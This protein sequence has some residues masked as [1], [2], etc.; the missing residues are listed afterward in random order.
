MLLLPPS[1]FACRCD[2]YCCGVDR[3]GKNG[4]CVG[5]MEGLAEWRQV[6]RETPTKRPSHADFARMCFHVHRVVCVRAE[7]FREQA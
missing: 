4:T 5:N 2:R 7:A 1:A 6:R 3:W